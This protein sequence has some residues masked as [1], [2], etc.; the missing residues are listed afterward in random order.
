V[1]ESSSE[2]RAIY[3]ALALV[4]GVLV[5]AALATRGALDTGAT[6]GFAFVALAV[7]GLAS[8]LRAAWRTRLPAAH[9]P[10]RT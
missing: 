1:N 4:G 2:E 6:F 9:A 8:Q 5:V 10:P 3:L 7:I